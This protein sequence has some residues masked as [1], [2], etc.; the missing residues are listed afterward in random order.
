MAFEVNA[1]AAQLVLPTPLA[2]EHAGWP[3]VTV[4]SVNGFV[5]HT[6][7]VNIDDQGF[8]WYRSWGYSEIG[9]F[10]DEDVNWCRG[11]HEKG[12]LEA[13]ALLAGRALR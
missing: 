11:W 2:A 5:H 12:S 9:L 8:R 7:A 3:Y 10:S 13:D 4:I 6:E 1:S